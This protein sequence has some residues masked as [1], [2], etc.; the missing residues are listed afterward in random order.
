VSEV[1]L[2]G[3]PYPAILQLARDEHSDL[4]V[5]G[6]HGGLASILGLGST[7]NHIM[8]ESICPVVSVRA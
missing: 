5:V 6:A 7:A 8:R 1:V 2:T 4:I 3:K